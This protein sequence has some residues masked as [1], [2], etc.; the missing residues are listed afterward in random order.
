MSSSSDSLA[1]ELGPK[2]AGSEPF[3]SETEIEEQP[4]Q[5]QGVFGTLRTP[6]WGQYC[7]DDLAGMIVRGINF[8]EDKKK[9]DCGPPLFKLMHADIFKTRLDEERQSHFAARP[10]SWAYQRWERRQKRKAAIARG[11][12]VP[13][14]K[15]QH[16]TTSELADDPAAPLIIINFLI[17]GSGHNMNL[18]LYFARRIKPAAL[19]RKEREAKS[20]KT[21]SSSSSSSTSTSS[22]S[23]SS[24]NSNSLSKP[25]PPPVSR[26]PYP[27]SEWDSPDYPHDLPRIAAF[28]GLLKKFLEGTDEFRDGRLK[29]VPRVAEGNWVVKKS[30]GRVPA[31][32]GKKVKQFYYRDVEKNYM[33]IDADLGTSVIAGRIISMVKGTCRG[34]VVDLSFLLQGENRSELPES[35]M[36]GIRM[37]RVDLDKITWLQENNTKNPPEFEC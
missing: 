18:V 35:L 8:M 29:I 17:P 14:I 11:E 31:I 19:L 1:G 2:V 27:G 9:I 33:E 37:I 26:S 23:S 16:Q 15:P 36:G 10:D 22:S 25:S 5:G 6:V 12:T 4:S 13:P 7:E 21:N 20:H 24:S 32:L 30:I 3:E 28:D 34:L